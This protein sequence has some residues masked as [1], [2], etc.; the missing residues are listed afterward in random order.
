[1]RFIGNKENI[2][3]KI[4]LILDSY[5]ISGKSFFD[6]FSGTTSVAKFF[7]K[8]DYEVYSSDILYMSY[9]LQR[10]Y[11]ENNE[12]LE[13]EGIKHLILKKSL[14]FNP[15]ESVIDYLNS[16]PP[17]EGFIFKNYTPLGT[18]ELEMPRMYFSNENGAKIDAIRLEIERLKAN[19]LLMENEYFFLL[20]LLIESVPFYSNIAGVYAA[21]HKKW[22]PRAVKDFEL[23]ENYPIISKK[24]CKAYIGNSIDLAKSIKADILYIDPPYNERQYAPNYHI[25]ETIARYDS[26]EIRGVTG[27][28]P[29]DNQKSDFCNATKA[30]CILDFIL[31]ESPAKHIVLSYNS[32]G[33]MPRESIEKIFR[34]YGKLDFEEFE[35]TRFKSN[36]NGLSKTKKHIMEQVYIL[37][38]GL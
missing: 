20:A 6:F 28:R 4:K 30:L 32:E 38:K 18:K 12:A 17:V 22:D 14:F 31:K 29:Y 8:L 9:C 27:M 34:K 21:F 11:I 7:K 2:I 10:A 13:F 37:R 33:I 1:M 35:Y 36:S 23:K 15:I 19:K 24:K 5:N 25:L 3:E 26:P 16:I